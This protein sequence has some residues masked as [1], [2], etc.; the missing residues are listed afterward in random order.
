MSKKKIKKN[1]S[2]WQT[3]TVPIG[4]TGC[5]PTRILKRRRR[6]QAFGLVALLRNGLL[7]ASWKHRKF[8]SQTEW[9]IL[10]IKF[11]HFYMDSFVIFLL[12][13]PF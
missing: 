13:P 1:T 7:V 8:A 5:R 6:K 9:L 10:S 11:I 12:L 4:T 2:Q 3:S